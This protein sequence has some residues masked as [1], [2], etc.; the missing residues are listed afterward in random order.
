MSTRSTVVKTVSVRLLDLIAYAQGL[1][2]ICGDISNAFIQATTNEKIFTRVGKEFGNRSGCISIIVKALY[3]LTT[4]AERFCTLLADYIRLLG[5]TP[6][7]Y[8]RDVWMK[9]RNA[10]D[11]FDYICTHIDNFKV[12]AKILRCGS[13]VS[14]VIFL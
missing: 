4:S 5:F 6:S 7:R 11:G 8:D 2:V 13:I 9:L 3:G 12:V 14:M 1:K 10:R